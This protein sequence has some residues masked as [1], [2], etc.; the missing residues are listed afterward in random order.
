[1][2]LAAT[3]AMHLRKKDGAASALIIL[4]LVLLIFFGILALVTAAADLRMAVRRAEWNQ[5]YY[6]SDSRAEQVLALIGQTCGEFEFQMADKRL[7]I[8]ELSGKLETDPAVLEQ[9][10]LLVDGLIRIDAKIAIDQQA[11]QGIEMTLLIDPG[12]E[13][14]AAPS[15]TITR[16]IWW[17]LP[18]DYDQHPGGVWEG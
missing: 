16:W 18:F 1:M 10:V 13:S 7:Q 8:D 14:G 5:A 9:Q 17:R 11:E 12:K 2:R 15:I 6:A 4:L 3:P